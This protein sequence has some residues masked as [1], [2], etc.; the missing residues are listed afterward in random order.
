MHIEQ[1]GRK[2]LKKSIKSDY[3][4]PDLEIILDRVDSSVSNIKEV[5]EELTTKVDTKLD[6][7]DDTLVNVIERVDFAITELQSIEIPKGEKGDQGEPGASP[8]TNE[9]V[10][11]V[12]AMVPPQKEIDE[13]SIISK[14]LS[15]IPENKP[16][17][18]VIQESI[19]QEKL[20]EDITPKLKLKIDNV[21]GLD[22]TLKLLDKRYIHGGGDTVSAGS[23]ITITNV[24]GTKQI[25][26]S[27]SIDSFETVSA[28]LSAYDSTLNYNGSGDITSIVYSNGVTKTFNYTGSDITS[29]VLSGS[30]PGGIELTKTLGYTLGNVTSITYS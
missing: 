17:L 13:N 15:A 1:I 21:E 18:K 19:D 28:N 8:D 27:A 30:T 5:T 12:L 3:V 22:R 11:E 9:I 20:I 16:S 10:K 26:S 7:V 6:E 24:N 29:I 14:V 2:F 23:G 4:K 25:S